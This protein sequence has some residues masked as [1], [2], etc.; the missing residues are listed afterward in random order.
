VSKK[1]KSF[2]KAL[3]FLCI[4][5]LV[6]TLIPPVGIWQS[7]KADDTTLYN[8]GID[9]YNGQGRSYWMQK[10]RIKQP[11]IKDPNGSDKDLYFN[12]EIYAEREKSVV[13][14][15][16]WDVPENQQYGN[17]KPDPNGYFLKNKTSGTRG[18]FRYM[19]YTKDGVAFPDPYFPP[20][21][22]GRKPVV[23]SNIIAQPWNNATCKGLVPE[24]SNYSPSDIAPTSWQTIW[25]A[26][27]NLIDR[28]GSGQRI[29]D[30]FTSL[31]DLQQKCIVTSVDGNGNGTVVIFHKVNGSVF[32]RS[33]TG[34]IPQGGTTAEGG[35]VNV[36]TDSVSGTIDSYS[37]L[38]VISGSSSNINGAV[39]KYNPATNQSPNIN[40][41]ITGILSDYL[42]SNSSKKFYE[43]LTLTR[44]DVAQYQTKINY[45]KINGQDVSSSIIGTYVEATPTNKASDTVTFKTSAPGISVALPPE[46]LKPGDNTVTIS[47]KVRVVFN[48]GNGQK[49][50]DASNSTSMS[51]TIKVEPSLQQP[52]LQLSVV[53]AQSEVTVTTD[54]SGNLIYT[55]S[56]ITHTV[57][58]AKVSN[59]TVPAGFKVKRLEFVIDRD[60]TRVASTT[61]P[62][63]TENYDTTATTITSFSQSKSFNYNTTYI[64]PGQT[65]TPAYYGKVRY[66]IADNSGKEYTSGWSKVEP[67]QATVTTK[68]LDPAQPTVNAMSDDK[69][70]LTMTSGTSW[71]PVQDTVT[72]KNIVA[73]VN[74]GGYT[75]SSWTIKITHDR[76][77]ASV[78]VPASSI[79]YNSNKSQATVSSYNITINTSKDVTQETFTIEAVVSLNGKTA[80]ATTTVSVPVEVIK[81]AAAPTITLTASPSSVTGNTTATITINA[82]ASVKNPPRQIRK[83]AVY[84]R[85]ATVTNDPNAQVLNKDTSA[86]SVT[87]SRTYT[88]YKVPAGPGKITFVGRA[89]VWY[90]GDPDSVYYDSDLAQ[91]DV[92]IDLPPRKVGEVTCD[93]EISPQ[94]AQATRNPFTGTIDPPTTDVQVGVSASIS[95]T[96]GKTISKWELYC[97]GDLIKTITGN[98]TSVSVP[99][100]AKMYTVNNDGTTPFNFTAKVYF[101]DGT[102]KQGTD[103]EVFSAVQYSKNSPPKCY[104]YAPQ[105]AVQGDDIVIIATG[106][107]DDIAYGDYVKVYSIDVSP[108]DGINDKNLQIIPGQGSDVGVLTFWTNKLTTY[109]VSAVV[110]DKLSGG[111]MA[112]G[113]ITIV[114]AVP[115]PKIDVKG[116]LK[117][118]RKILLDGSSSYSGSKR[119]TILWDKAQWKIE[120]YSGLSSSDIIV[121]DPTTGTQQ[122]NIIAKKPGQIKVTLTITNSYGNTQ[123]TSRIITIKPDE[124]PVA[125]FTMPTKII[126][127][128]ADS[129]QATIQITSNSYSPDGDTI[130]KHAWF[131][132]YDSNNDGNFDDE[133]W[134]IRKS[135]GTWQAVGNWTNVQNFDI[136]KVDTGNV[137]SITLKTP[138]VGKY[139]VALVVRE[140]L[141]LTGIGNWVSI[142]DLQKSNTFD[143][144]D[145]KCVAEVINIAPFATISSSKVEKKKVNITILTDKTS[146]TDM[147][148]ISS[149]LSQFKSDITPFGINLSVNLFDG[150]NKIISSFTGNVYSCGTA[151]SQIPGFDDV[152][153]YF[154]GVSNQAVLLSNGITYGADLKS[155]I[156]GKQNGSDVVYFNGTKVTTFSNGIKKIKNAIIPLCY[157]SNYSKYVYTQYVYVLTNDNYLYAVSAYD[158]STSCILSGIKDFV[159]SLRTHFL[160]IT[161]YTLSCLLIT[162]S[163]EIYA[164][165]M[166][167]WSNGYTPS[168]Y[169]HPSLKIGSGGV[170]RIG[171][172]GYISFAT[173]KIGT[174]GVYFKG[175]SSGSWYY[176][177]WDIAKLLS[178]SSQMIENSTIPEATV[179]CKNVYY[180]WKVG[181]D[182]DYL[183]QIYF[184]SGE[185]LNYN[186]NLIY[187]KT[188]NWND[189][190]GAY[191][192]S[193]SSLP[194]FFSN[195]TELT[196]NGSNV[197]WRDANNNVY[198]YSSSNNTTSQLASGVQFPYVSASTKY[199]RQVS[200]YICYLQNGN[201]YRNGALYATATPI[202]SL[203]YEPAINS[204]KDD[205]DN[206]VIYLSDTQGS[207]ISAGWG[208]YFP[209]SAIDKNFLRFLTS[210]NTKFYAVSPS[211]TFDQI[212]DSRIQQVT[213]R[214][215]ANATDGKLYDS[216]GNAIATLDQALADIKAKYTNPQL[217]PD[218]VYVLADEEKVL[219]YP[220]WEDYENDPIINQRWRYEHDETVF[221]NSLGKAE[222]DSIWLNAPIE[223]F[224]KPGK[225]TI[226]FQVQDNPP[227]GTSDFDE[228]KLWSKLERQMILYVH[229]RPVADFTVKLSGGKPV[230]TDNSYDPDHQYNRSD[231]GIIAWKWQYKTLDDST[232]TDTTLSNLQ[233]MTLQSG[234]IYLIK[235]EVQDCDGPNGVGV[236]SKPKIAMIDLSVTN[237]PPVADFTVDS[238]I[239]KGN[240]P[241]NLTDKSY[242]PDND[243]ITIWHWWIYKASDNS[244]VKDFGETANNNISN[245]KSY[246]ATLAEDSYKL[247]LQVKDSAGNYSTITTKQFKVYSQSKDT[248]PDVVNNPPA[249]TFTMTI[250]DHRTKL[251][252]TTTYSDPDGD[253]KNAEQ[254]YIKFNGQTQYF[255]KLPDTLESAGYTYDGTYEIGY[256]VQDNPTGRSTK[257]KPLWSNWYVQTYYIST[258]VTINA[259]LEKFEK[260][261]KNRAEA[262]ILKQRTVKASEIR[263]GEALIVKARTT[264]Y[265]EKIE[266]WFDRVETTVKGQRV[267]KT[268][269]GYWEARDSQGNLTGT[270]QLIDLHT[271]L[272]PDK[273]GA[274]YQ[275][276]WSSNLDDKKLIVRFRIHHY[277]SWAI[278]KFPA[279]AQHN[280]WDGVYRWSDWT[281]G[282]TFDYN[283]MLRLYGRPSYFLSNNNPP[284]K[285][286]IKVRAYRKNVD[287]SY[288]T[289]DVDLPV[290]IKG[291]LQY[292]TEIITP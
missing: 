256:R 147:N 27:Y 113:Q 283:E 212:L 52:Q 214:Q 123:S 50:I 186:N 114:P 153:F 228:Y 229:R 281:K 265:V 267:T 146:T 173:T 170:S 268:I 266:V 106:S 258:P 280:L 41:F 149:K 131:Y 242:D 11:S 14:G 154:P 107:D 24:L 285:L 93:G 142:Y 61:T 262:E 251:R 139:K 163:N 39:L 201:I 167:S 46:M 273:T 120:P 193:Y 5:S 235:L 230:I 269:T 49:W 72:I 220:Y 87:A 263:I 64:Q 105:T 246:I 213:L 127:D 82:N 71:T 182:V 53:P 88:N 20:E 17:F 29:G 18:W 85:K 67:V 152:Y 60:N 83:W 253:P 278:E 247:S 189:N 122:V 4:L 241:S 10:A 73:K 161:N 184:P 171:T 45:V 42:G 92:M 276:S 279:A 150:T 129:S 54:N 96:G 181:V 165:E 210:T 75:V 233:S 191:E 160:N 245:V 35:I 68:V 48:T 292:G 132:A 239:L 199:W 252:P 209:F 57:K 133:T 37:Y 80:K 238:E 206:Y 223:V 151:T 12:C 69:I 218:P 25:N 286:W 168:Y 183:Q 225:Y 260:R 55:P 117:T 65:G 200:E 207:N 272:I 119:A 43:E 162:T 81:P 179:N 7:V 211:S 176:A 125:S 78:T 47:G 166:A 194:G 116:D 19:G 227:P 134:Y 270:M 244:L 130:A 63:Y 224:T 9:S 190:Y 287:G 145:S 282:N 177:W 22:D 169:S 208:S 28:N 178:T 34:F 138:N 137:T 202:Q 1:H 175:P 103:T 58:P 180:Y 204:Y 90:S 76:T 222:F 158:G 89:R 254:W 140:G 99:L 118:N 232:W 86:T 94:T 6:L 243:T 109:N 250:T 271:W 198:V 74:P 157:D 205:A 32:Y 23:Y 111:D 141:D 192:I 66:V 21:G 101:T 275:N 236:W 284:D 126:R 274:P 159:M 172:E 259:W 2:L 240:Q 59:M 56:S 62:D 264:G 102:S 97:N 108:A 219:Y 148:T 38:T 174:D 217:T 196:T 84:I 255:D 203:S 136:E 156:I 3:S 143:W 195:L 79:S 249:G 290:L 187:V 30:L 100:G 257:L 185:I 124:P 277:N 261:A 31:S 164:S 289:T 231:K 128:P 221:D 115:V 36:T 288:K 77:G 248:E 121:I 215:L 40:V 95:D 216:T 110:V 98:N 237:N 104:L 8:G 197:Y 144:D 112:T 16:P 26:R 44:N 155:I 234:K 188:I 15:E 135:D 51:F 70:T 226:T 33:Y 91:V 291:E 13:Y